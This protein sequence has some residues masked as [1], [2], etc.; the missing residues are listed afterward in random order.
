MIHELS[1]GGI[2]N[3]F[4][5]EE[6]RHF[7]GK[8]VKLEAAPPIPWSNDEL[9][10]PILNQKH[11]LFLG[12]DRLD[13][14]PLDILQ[15]RKLY[16]DRKKQPCFYLDW[17][18]K[19]AFAQKPLGPRW[20][21][22]TIELVPN[23]KNLT[24]DPLAALLPPT[25]EMPSAIERVTANLLWYLMNNV[26]MDSERDRCAIAEKDSQGRVVE[27]AGFPIDGLAIGGG[28]AAATALRGVAASRRLPAA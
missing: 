21:W 8:K 1:S 14:K 16:S 12:L 13:G 2:F 15:W 25:Y 20:Y 5:L 24:Y 18:L 17:Y 4:G 6:W 19:E 7:F 27:V 11:F 23:S 28:F 22:V 26:Y 9:K 3:Y 10:Q